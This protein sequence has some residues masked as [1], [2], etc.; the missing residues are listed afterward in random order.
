HRGFDVQSLNNAKQIALAMRLYADD[1]DG[2]FPS[3]T[4]RNGAPTTTPVADSNTAF[5]QLFPTYVSEEALFW[6]PQS[7][8]C[9]TKPPDEIT[10]TP[11]LD[12]PVKTLEQGE[13]EWAYVLGLRAD[14]SK[15]F[16]LVADGFANPAAHTYTTD[17]S[18]KGGHLEGGRAIVIHVDGSGIITHLDPATLQVTGSNGGTSPGDI[19][20]TGHAAMGWLQPENKVVNP[21]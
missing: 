12:T 17:K 7:A 16:P 8:F 2:K 15:D 6:V 9:S 4:L 20:T 3:F 1:H 19:F 18:N 11:P 5:A 10:D 13:N 21:R 14:S